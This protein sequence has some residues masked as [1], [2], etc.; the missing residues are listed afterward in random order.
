M[1]AYFSEARTSREPR[2]TTRPVG[3]TIWSLA[4]PTTIGLFTVLGANLLD[5]IYI[6]RLGARELA[7]LG[8]CFPVIFTMSA[9]GFGFGAGATAVIAQAIGRGDGHIVRQ[10]ATNTLL[11]SF[12][13]I[14]ALAILGAQSMDV[15]FRLLGASN[16]VLPDLRAYMTVYLW[17]LPV[18]LLPVV[19]NGF[20]R[21]T[22]ETVLPAMVMIAG[23][24]MNAAVSPV[25][26][27]G[28][29]GM[30]EL[31]LAGA[32][33]GVV[34][35]RA[36][37]AIVSLVIIHYREHL[38]DYSIGAIRQFIPAVA[39]VVTIGLPATMAQIITPLSGAALT[40]LL[41]GF[42]E[43]T[44]AA[45]AVGAR[46]EALF[47]IAFWALQSGVAPFVGQNFGARRIDRLA[48][49]A[50]IVLGFSLVWGV[51]CL[52]VALV[53]GRAI[54]GFFTTDPAVAEIASR[55]FVIVSAGMIG[56]GL[57]LGATAF[58]YA[59]GRPFLAT[60]VTALRFVAL[61][62]PIGFFLSRYFGPDG[63]FVAA[64]ISYIG[65]GLLS[66]VLMRAVVRTLMRT[67]GSTS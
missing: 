60:A 63:V 45:F 15:L 43:E 50:R 65:A 9:V 1:D 5:T 28:M 8:F 20:I 16:E 57:T 64:A 46:V 17:G 14:V 27:F 39:G 2:L 30:P 49:A 61:Y 25:L 62:V 32:A 34:A 42:G 67:H 13:V 41:S 19:L 6:G 55:Y 36:T 59:M 11:L 40:R 18:I 31:G 66:A 54:T 48:E 23:A 21:A 37:I 33:W 47:L 7:A 26:I 52:G 58:F 4:W 44:V 29:F 51:L 12:G 53:Y 3:R 24:V 35:A 10:V 38:L 22:G 56:A